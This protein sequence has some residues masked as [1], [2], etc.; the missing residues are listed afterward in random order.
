MRNND[1]GEHKLKTHQGS[2]EDTKN[3]FEKLMLPL[4]DTPFIK[5][6]ILVL[7]KLKYLEFG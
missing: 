7:Y 3:R 1:L 6:T 4:L 2:E 5:N